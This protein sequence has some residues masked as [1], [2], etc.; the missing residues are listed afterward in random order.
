[1]KS[2]S[3]GSMNSNL[4]AKYQMGVLASCSGLK[5]VSTFHAAK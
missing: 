3:K 4:H 2:K 1:M 5:T